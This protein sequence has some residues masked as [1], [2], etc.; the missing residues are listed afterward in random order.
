M[1]ITKFS[2]FALRVLI[3]LA[4]SDGELRSTR[5]LAEMHNL[6][7]NHLAKVTQWLTSEGYVDS[8]RGRSG[9]LRLAME[10]K[11]ISLGALMRK[12]ERGSPLV[13]CMKDGYTGCCV[14]TPACGLLPVLHDAQEA[15]FQS[16]DKRTLADVMAGNRGMIN[17]LKTL[18]KHRAEA[19]TST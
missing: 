8:I 17:L 13:E 19:E 1:Q 12:S 7:F 3:H 2:D 18:E 6:S 11:D 10:P 5:E 14:M 9:G 15:F 16:L 4:V